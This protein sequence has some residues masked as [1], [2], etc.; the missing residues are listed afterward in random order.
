MCLIEEPETHLHPS[1][2][3]RLFERLGE[4]SRARN[5]Q[6][7]ITSHSAIAINSDHWGRASTQLF[8]IRKVYSEPIGVPLYMV[9]EVSRPIDLLDSLGS[10]ASDIMQSNGVIWVEGPSDRIYIKYWIG[11]LAK[12][13]KRS[14]PV[15]NRDYSFSFYGGS[16]LSHFS[17][18]G[19]DKLIDI[20]RLNR[21]A[22]VVID[23]DH[24]FTLVNGRL[25]ANDRARS[26]S[27][28]REA[29]EAFGGDSHYAWITDGYT[30]ESYLPNAFVKGYFHVSTDGKLTLRKN[31]SKVNAAQVYVSRGSR[32]RL[33]EELQKHVQK[34]ITIISTW[35]ADT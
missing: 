14:A 13:L 6:L 29:I 28:I 18:G 31:E 35:N 10:K 33:S 25:E 12:R 15:E 9:A 3:K 23:N 1:L 27:R 20:L 24:Q 21:N 11:I 4:V 34:V 16:I 19:T 22:V 17:A 30:I 8:E 7:I 2:Q 26:K 5:L 32:P